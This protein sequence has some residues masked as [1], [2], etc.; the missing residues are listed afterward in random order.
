MHVPIGL[1]LPA[2]GSAVVTLTF[3][4]PQKAMRLLLK[5]TRASEHPVFRL[6]ARRATTCQMGISFEQSGRG[7][8][9]FGLPEVSELAVQHGFVKKDA[10][11][12]APLASRADLA[13]FFKAYECN[14]LSSFRKRFCEQPLEP[15]NAVTFLAAGA[16]TA[17]ARA[18]VRM[19]PTHVVTLR[20]LQQLTAFRAPA[21]ARPTFSRWRLITRCPARQSRSSVTRSS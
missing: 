12:H 16:A 18:A 8:L 10:P 13:A 11:P 7:P 6:Q 17:H 9:Q 21:R 1:P 3:C 5:P 20:L 4:L 15:I 2:L 14:A 19:P